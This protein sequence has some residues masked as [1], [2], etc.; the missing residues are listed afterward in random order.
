M[1]ASS[2]VLPARTTR[3][4]V[5]V[6]AWDFPVYVSG[7]GL[8]GRE[9]N[10]DIITT[11][12]IKVR[13]PSPWTAATI[14]ARFTPACG[15]VRPHVGGQNLPEWMRRQILINTSHMAYN[16]VFFKSGCA[17]VKEGNDFDLVGTYDEQFQCSFCELLFLPQAEWGNLR[18]IFRYSTA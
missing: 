2:L 14:T 17:A 8:D 7:D 1:I 18:D 11:T 16:G 4:I 9:R 13:T 5:F 6:F 3:H 15:P 12:S 10:S